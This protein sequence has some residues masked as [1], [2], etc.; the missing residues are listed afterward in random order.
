MNRLERRLQSKKMISGGCEGSEIYQPNIYTD[1][2]ENQEY[3]MFFN[4]VCFDHGVIEQMISN[5]EDVRIVGCY[6]SVKIYISTP[7]GF[8]HQLMML[9]EYLNNYP[10]AIKF[11][12]C[13]EIASCGALLPLMV[14]HAELEYTPTASAMFHFAHCRIHSS[15]LFGNN[16]SIDGTASDLKSIQDLNNYL[17]EEYYSKLAITDEEKEH[18]LKGK[19][20]FI[21]RSRIEYIYES[22]KEFE[23][24]ERDLKEVKNEIAQKKAELSNELAMLED[25]EAKLDEDSLD[26]QKEFG[27]QFNEQ[28]KLVDKIIDTDVDTPPKKKVG[29]PKKA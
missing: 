4:D 7:G 17:W 8:A 24:Y 21:D 25:M 28:G 3:K 1:L 15:A 27:L 2:K 16:A 13:G 22:F 20:V 26:F 11:V 29:R 19:D 18:I 5:L 10:L 23:F 6:D 9:V 14:A 12:V